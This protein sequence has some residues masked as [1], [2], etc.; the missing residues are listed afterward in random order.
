MHR[1]RQHLRRKLQCNVVLQLISAV[2]ALQ[3]YAVRAHCALPTWTRASSWHVSGAATCRS[4]SYATTLDLSTCP[5]QGRARASGGQDT[6]KDRT[7]RPAAVPGWSGQWQRR[8]RC[9][10]MRRR[11]RAFRLLV[12]NMPQL[13]LA[14][15]PQTARL[16]KNENTPRDDGRCSGWPRA[17]PSFF[18]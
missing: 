10:F 15:M 8:C 6:T 14:P 5:V 11:R 7:S 2:A 12:G 3:R 17:T 18:M 9:L 4:C 13:K 16:T 1:P